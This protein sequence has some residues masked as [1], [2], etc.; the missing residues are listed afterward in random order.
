MFPYLMLSIVFAPVAAGIMLASRG[1]RQ[2]RFA[3]FLALMAVYCVLYV[4]MLMF[5]RTRWL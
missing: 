4:A 1:R 2:G 5:L 3:Q